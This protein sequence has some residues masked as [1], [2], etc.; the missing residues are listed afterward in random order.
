MTSLTDLRKSLRKLQ[1]ILVKHHSEFRARRVH[2]QY[3]YDRLR[4]EI[5]AEPILDGLMPD[6]VEDFSELDDWLSFRSRQSNFVKLV[7]ESFKPAFAKLRDDSSKEV[8]K[9]SSGRENST[10][11]KLQCALSIA[12]QKLDVQLSAAN[13]IR[14]RTFIS[15][16]NVD[17]AFDDVERWTKFTHSLLVQLFESDEIAH[18][19]SDWM[20]IGYDSDIPHSRINPTLTQQVEFLRGNIGPKIN[21]LKSIRER[22]ELYAV[23]QP[24]TSAIDAAATRIPVDQG[25]LAMTNQPSSKTLARAR[26]LLLEAL[27]SSQKRTVLN[28]GTLNAN[29]ELEALDLEAARYC[30]EHGW[31]RPGNTEFV[32]ILTQSGIEYSTS[33]QRESHEAAVIDAT[34]RILEAAEQ[35][36]WEL[37]WIE[38]SQGSSVQVN[39]KPLANTEE[40]Q[41]SFHE[42]CCRML[43]E[44]GYITKVAGILYRVTEKGRQAL[45]NR[46]APSVDASINRGNTKVEVDPKL[47]FVVHGRDDKVRENVELFL[48]RV[49]LEPIVLFREVSGGKVVIEKL[50]HY[51]GKVGYAVVILNPEDIGYLKEEYNNGTK[52]NDEERARQNVVFEMGYF[53]ALLGRGKVAALQKGGVTKPSDIDGIVYIP[54]H[55]ENLEWKITLAK[56]LLA[57]GLKVDMSQL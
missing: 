55:D 54:M 49:G 17:S 39:N 15:I 27:K 25:H 16:T 28:G 52:G 10:F 18:E 57:A 6:F 38:H 14:D 53:F 2:D 24:A 40:E 43:N 3:E 46:D 22:L 50:E 4:S 9:V 37:N 7:E 33:L 21:R 19:F 12:Q 41:D 45:Y 44:T 51:A 5:L 13:E 42:A 32:F 20:K 8:A 35:N 47:V 48:H 36:K 26:Q 11:P 31:S 56:E 1:E 30:H 23:N 29:T 34:F